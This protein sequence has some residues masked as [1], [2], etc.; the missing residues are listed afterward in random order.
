MS[1]RLPVH[2]R[3]ND[4]A[5]GQP[6]PVRIRFEAQGR[7]FAPFGRLDVFPTASGV[8]VGGHLQLGSQKFYYI[9]EIGRA[10]V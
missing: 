3:V 10:H 7:S 5:T 6:T 4:T 1:D 8:D 9:D 2:I